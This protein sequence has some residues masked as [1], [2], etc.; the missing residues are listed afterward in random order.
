M[1]SSPLPPARRAKQVVDDFD[2]QVFVVG[3][4]Q[5][6]FEQGMAA[7][8]EWLPVL[9]ARPERAPPATVS[10]MGGGTA[11]AAEELIAPCRE[12]IA[13]YKTPRSVDFAANLPRNASGK[14]QVN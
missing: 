1:N 2:L 10:E 12:R 8:T 3:G 14:R 7:R 9:L 13:H 4:A 11:T 5:H 6:T